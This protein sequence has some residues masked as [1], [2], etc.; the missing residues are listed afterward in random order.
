MSKIRLLALA[1]VV[2]LS[3]AGLTQ[4]SAA[5]SPPLYTLTKTIPIGGGIKWDYLDFDPASDSVF[6][7][8][9]TE[10]TVLDAKTGNV[11][12]NV[13]GLNGSHGIAI[14]PLTG[15][16]FADSGKSKT[17]SIFDLKTLKTIKV[18][19]ALL[20]ADGMA[21][22]PSTHQVFVAG[23]DANAVLPV[24]TA[25]NKPGKSIALGGAPEFLVT[26]GDGALYVNINDKN[27]IVKVDTKTDTIVARWH[28]A[29][30]VGPTGLAIDVASQRLFSSCENATMVIVDAENG[31]ILASL[32]IGKGTDAA[33]FDPQRKL[34]FSSN[35]DGSLSVI[36]ETNPND[37]SV[38]EDIKTEPGARTIALDSK[39]GRIFL[40]TAVVQSIG[41]PKRVGGAPSYKFVPGSAKVLIYDPTRA[42]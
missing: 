15:F 38:V 12:G 27:E 14:D 37:F 3:L 22:D 32:P 23:G 2:A 13:T 25:T 30:C 6:I 19:P 17:T 8:H 7:S 21:F 20:D 34:A 18:I 26:D 29:S 28:L 41:A 24:D 36:R 39:T 11:I 35:R 33:A 40:V 31:K 10:L 16:G 5:A 42:D 9:G 1:S 4:I